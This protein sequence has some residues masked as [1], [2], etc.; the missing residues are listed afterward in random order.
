MRALT[1]CVQYF[2]TGFLVFLVVGC[3]TTAIQESH[4]LIGNSADGNVAKVYF[5]RPDS[6]FDGVKGNAFTISLDGQKLLTLAKGEYTLVNLKHYSGDVTVESSA[7]VNRGGM[8]TQVTVKESQPFV[9]EEATTYYVTFQESPR[10]YI[11]YCITQESARNTA[12]K[13]NPVGNAVASPL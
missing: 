13:L 1:R 6:G 12:K 5:I 9:F 7:V 10:G 4:P 2:T 11:P 8:N 3:G